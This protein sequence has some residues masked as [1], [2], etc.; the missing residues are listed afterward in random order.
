MILTSL[1][2]SWN[3]IVYYPRFGK[4]SIL[5]IA[6]MIGNLCVPITRKRTTSLVC[7]KQN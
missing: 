4:V 5:V 2:Y 3:W 1:R 6:P 7:L